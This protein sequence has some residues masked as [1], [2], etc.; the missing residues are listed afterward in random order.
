MQ[1][2][3]RPP[4]ARLLGLEVL[5]IAPSRDRMTARFDGRE[6]FLN[7]A[8]FIQGGLLT[9][10]LDEALSVALYLNTNGE[11]AGSTIDMHT[12]FVRPTRPG[13]IT[14]RARVVNLGRSIAFLSGDLFDHESTLC[15]TASASARLVD[16]SG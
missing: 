4:S 8:G 6:Q 5:D 12:H 9:A 3:N 16:V 7:P 11:R 14:V 1:F 13:E 15:A 10:M 2:E